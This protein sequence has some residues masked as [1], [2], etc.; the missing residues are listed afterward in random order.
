MKFFTSII[1][2]LNLTTAYATPDF[3]FNTKEVNNKL[4]IT[5][6]RET[7]EWC[8][9][10]YINIPDSIGGVDVVAIEPEVF[11]QKGLEQLTLGRSIKVIYD[12][13]FEGNNI[14]GSLSIPPSVEYIGESAFR[15]N[16][17]NRV[18]ITNGIGSMAHLMCYYGGDSHLDRYICYD[19]DEG[20][21]YNKGITSI[22]VFQ[23]AFADNQIEQLTITGYPFLREDVF[24]NNKINMVKVD[25]SL[26]LD[27]YKKAFNSS[28]AE[29]VEVKVKHPCNDLMSAMNTESKEGCPKEYKFMFNP[30]INL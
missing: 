9:P 13:Q 20:P 3:C 15:G 5:G 10:K 30:V 7:H 24:K 27:F 22:E 26:L 14:K 17:I 23:N 8:D 28:F 16:Q 4:I 21:I 19:E 12:H 2:F 25:N 6:Y 11:Y 1:L 29:S 18:Y